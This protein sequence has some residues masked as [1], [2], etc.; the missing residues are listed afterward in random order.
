[1]AR[2]PRQCYDT[3]FFH[4]IVQ[5]INKEYI[6]K[7]EKYI[8][9]YISL[10]NIYKE[11]T[12]IEIISY[13]IMNNHAH[14]LLYTDKISEMSKYMQRVNTKYA[15]Y[16]NY[17]ENERVGY[18]FRDRYVSEPILNEQYLIKCINY[19][20]CN[21]VK[22]HMVL[23][24]E[25]YKYSTYKQYIS[26]E[27][28]DLLKD[29]FNIDFSRECLQEV[30]NI[31]IFQD[32]EFDINKYINQKINKFLK[33]GNIEKDELIKYRLILKLLIRNLRKDKKVKYTDIMKNLNLTKCQMER[34]K[35]R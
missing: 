33:V 27:K 20:H 31:D 12:K 35:K 32:I 8:T 7:K 23:S 1:M 5:G 26:G 2:L 6:F 28:L 21:P 17:M 14:I 4:I 22:A 11:N 29:L 30:E 19:I 18:V 24:C 10:L 16:Y 34:L 3:S 9:K 15:K 13:C 25:D